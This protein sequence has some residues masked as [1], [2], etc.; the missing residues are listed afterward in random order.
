MTIIKSSRQVKFPKGDQ[1]SLAIGIILTLLTVVFFMWKMSGNL[2]KDWELKAV[3]VTTPTP[4]L[5]SI[6][7]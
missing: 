2:I 3:P 4:P 5:K 7:K 1:I 6:E